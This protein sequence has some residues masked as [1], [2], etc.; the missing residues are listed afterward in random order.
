MTPGNKNSKGI[1]KRK[2]AFNAQ[3]F[4]DSVGVKR[5]TKE[6]KRAEIV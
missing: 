4:L 5:T 6:F 2:G 1:S 3:A